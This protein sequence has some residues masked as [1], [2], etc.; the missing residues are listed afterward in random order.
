[1]S[2]HHSSP[3]Q[4]EPAPGW[5]VRAIASV[6]R[7][8][9]HHVCGA[10][11]RTLEWGDRG[12]RPVVLVHGGAA[13]AHWFDH[14]APLLAHGRHVLA[15]DLSGHGESDRRE[16]YR[17][18]LWVE[19]VVEIAL[20]AGAAPIVV[21]HSMGG[22]VALEA[23][24]THGEELGGVIVADSPLRPRRTR[25]GPARNHNRLPRVYS[26]ETEILAR[27]RPDPSDGPIAPYLHAH[28]ARRSIRAVPGGFS[29]QFDPRF[30]MGGGMAL[31]EVTTAA[32]RVAFVRGERGM[33]DPGV[34]DLLARRLGQDTICTTVADCGHHLMLDRPLAF[35]ATVDEILRSW[36]DC[37]AP[38]HSQEQ[39]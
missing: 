19:E 16:E 6:P 10:R 1:M 35:V 27:F 18:D 4:L 7:I 20:G 8:G 28:V 15:L 29:W 32:C 12:D 21:G 26:S 17:R 33:L 31:D 39:P 38:R 34:M 13:N 11:I 2:A 37:P 9:F 24:G 25:H 5:F 22:L 23:A 14:V 30:G 36:Q 3:V